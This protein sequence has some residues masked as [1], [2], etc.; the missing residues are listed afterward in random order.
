MINDKGKNSI[1]NI[2]KTYKLLLSKSRIFNFDDTL[3]M[4]NDLLKIENEKVKNLDVKV[5]KIK[6]KFA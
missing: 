3:Q 6:P 1:L 5:T 4:N 2:P